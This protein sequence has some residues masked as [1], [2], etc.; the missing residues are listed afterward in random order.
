MNLAFISADEAKIFIFLILLRLISLITPP[1]SFIKT[2]PAA[3]SH[4]F[5]LF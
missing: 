2:I 3:M 1:A 5:K 4:K